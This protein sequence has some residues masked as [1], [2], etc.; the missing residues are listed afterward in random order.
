[1]V[2]EKK[3]GS[4]MDGQRF[5]FGVFLGQY[6]TTGRNEHGTEIIANKTGRQHTGALEHQS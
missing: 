6:K 4:V 5:M 2:D 1:M 3:G